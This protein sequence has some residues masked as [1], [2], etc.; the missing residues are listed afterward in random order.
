[1]GMGIEIPSPQ[2]PWDFIARFLALMI[3]YPLQ[4]KSYFGKYVTRRTA[5][6]HSFPSKNY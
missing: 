6:T 1:M 2:Q 3:L 5:Y 4:I